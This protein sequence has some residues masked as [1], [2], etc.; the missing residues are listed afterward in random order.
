M[1]ARDAKDPQTEALD[2]LPRCLRQHHARAQQL[3]W[4]GS[5]KLSAVAGEIRR[6]KDADVTTQFVVVSQYGDLL[7]ELQEA[8]DPVTYEV[9]LDLANREGKKLPEGSRVEYRKEAYDPGTAVDGV[10]VKV[11]EKKECKACGQQ[12]VTPFPNICPACYVECKPCTQEDKCGWTYKPCVGVLKDGVACTRDEDCAKC[13]GKYGC[14]RVYGPGDEPAPF[15]YNGPQPPKDPADKDRKK[16]DGQL[17]CT[18]PRCT[19]ERKVKKGKK[20]LDG[21]N[22]TPLEACGGCGGKYGC[23]A[24]Y[25]KQT[26]PRPTDKDGN[27]DEEK[28]SIKCT[29]AACRKLRFC[30]PARGGRGPKPA[31]AKPND[32]ALFKNTLRSLTKMECPNCGQRHT[33]PYPRGLVCDKC[34]TEKKLKELTDVESGLPK[35]LYTIAHG[36]AEAINVVKGQLTAKAH[37]CVVPG[38]MVRAACCKDKEG[39]LTRGGF[40]NRFRPGDKVTATRPA[41][42]AE[43]DL[44]VGMRVK[45]LEVAYAGASGVVYKL[46][47]EKN[48][49]DG[50]VVDAAASRG[51]RN[52]AAALRVA[53]FSGGA[54]APAVQKGGAVTYEVKVRPKR[55]AEV[56]IV[57]CLNVPRW[58]TSR[59]ASGGPRES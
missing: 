49:E 58:K 31:E 47:I 15:A 3:G 21:R 9:D 1:P 35:Y 18:D 44:E 19:Q 45:V 34:G 28:G 46:I 30:R 2:K 36:G 29:S 48:D 27:F 50:V 17:L 56:K 52:K 59:T 39:C 11:D 43:E 40:D 10:I 14:G 55:G 41:L 57:L 53:R 23:G 4:R 25:T 20:V 5:A 16:L 32:R 54:A 26:C 22:D 6:L 24:K 38:K 12:F 42:S 8:Y 37:R 33:A 13:H 51:P 7:D